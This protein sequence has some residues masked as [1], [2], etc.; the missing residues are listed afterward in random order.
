MARAGVG[1]S[2]QSA[3]AE[4]ARDNGLPAQDRRGPAAGSDGSCDLCS[5]GLRFVA[6][7]ARR[8]RRRR[9]TH[10][11]EGVRL[12]TVAR[13]A[14]RR[15]QRREGPAAFVA[16]GRPQAALEG[17][18]PRPGILLAHHRRRQHLRHRRR[19]PASSHLRP[20]PR[21][22]ALSHER[23]R[24]G[25]LPRR[26]SGKELWAVEVLNRFGARNVTWRI[27]ECLLVDGPR[28]IVTPTGA[29][30]ASPTAARRGCSS[31]PPK[32]WRWSDASGCLVR[33]KT[34]LR[35]RSSATAG[36][37]SAASRTSTATMSGE[38]D[39]RPGRHPRR[40]FLGLRAGSGRPGGTS[41]IRMSLYH[42]SQRVRLG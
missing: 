5:G 18:G 35:T 37:T 13:T 16:G 7:R 15:R 6:C 33:R 24:P 2:R 25:R 19:R 40:R 26:R 31:P 17:D 3:P 32:G 8:R 10:R 30:T 12:A 4:K 34:S 27:S 1:R 36:C 28:V 23:P 14:A 42:T 38:R 21:R 41:R 39:G 20:A 22:Q 29:S 11:L 9:A